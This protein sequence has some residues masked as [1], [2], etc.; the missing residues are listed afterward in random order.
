MH[1][2]NDADGSL[3]LCVDCDC[4][5]FMYSLCARVFVSVLVCVLWGAM[6]G[7]MDVLSIL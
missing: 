6:D 2:H 1:S 7:W 5:T 3:L 4:A